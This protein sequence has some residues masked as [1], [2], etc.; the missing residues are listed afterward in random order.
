M[1]QLSSS[2]SL[3]IASV[4][5]LLLASARAQFPP[6]GDDTMPSLGQFKIW[7]TPAFRPLFTGYPGYNPVR[8]E[9]TSPVLADRQTVIGR[10]SPHTHGSVADVS[11]TPCGTAN[12][13]VRDSHF[14]IQPFGFQA[15]AGTREVHTHVV[16]FNMVDVQALGARIRAGSAAPLQPPSFGEVES[17]NTGGVGN[18]PDFPAESFFNINAEVDLPALASMTAILYHTTPLVV[19]HPSITAFP[20]TIIYTHG[21]SSAVPVFFRNANPTFWNANDFLGFLVLAGHGA[22]MPAT[23][24]NIAAFQAAIQNQPPIALPDGGG[25]G[26]N[27][28]VGLSFLG[29]P[30]PS[31]AFSNGALGVTSVAQVGMIPHPDGTPGKFLGGATVTGLAPSLGGQG[32]FDV[33][34]FTYDRFADVVTLNPSAAV[35]NTTGTEFALNWGLN[36]LYAVADRATGVH[37]AEAP[38]VGG[39]LLNLRPVPAGAAFVDPCPSVVLGQPVLFFNNPAG[40]LAYRRHDVANAALV[41]PTVPVTQTP[42]GGNV[43]HSSWPMT[44]GDGEAAALI[45]C[46]A[47]SAFSASDWNWQGDLDPA[48]PPIPQQPTPAPFE[49]N[50]CEAGGR[51]YMPRSTSGVYQVMEVNVVG[52][53]GDVVPASGGTADLVAFTPIKTGPSQPDVSIFI[54]STQFGPPL[55]VPG[56]QNLFGLDP[57]A[58]VV[59]TVVGHDPNTGRAHLAIPVPPLAP[60]SIP[61]Q[62]LTLVN[63]PSGPFHFTSTI[64]V[65]IQ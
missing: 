59:L 43:S 55:S 56:F 5:L 38:T 52:L 7:V 4:S 1:G 42:G 34:A 61:F 28:P 35:F 44:G 11:G 39:Q 58:L 3:G 30:A 47:N 46:E 49:N 6:Q 25:S 21:N 16:S 22:N 15:P 27:G 57:L 64:S 29:A 9:L 41:G 20:P 37:Q 48:T 54:L 36:G 12:V 62:V 18:Q 65:G 60:G 26:P 50:G 53:L 63:F 33:V 8:G 17:R 32:G 19:R 40:G 45:A 51:V 23:P 10:S 13:V 24:A 14:L 2:R 31:A